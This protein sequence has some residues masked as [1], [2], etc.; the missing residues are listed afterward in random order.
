LITKCQRLT[1]D[2]NVA[3]SSPAGR[4]LYLQASNRIPAN[5][6][7]LAAGIGIIAVDHSSTPIYT[8]SAG[9]ESA[10]KVHSR[11]IIRDATM[12]LFL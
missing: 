9:L 7:R 6:C 3:G 1:S 10:Q 12:N 5:V 4:A 8:N 11:A 2:Q